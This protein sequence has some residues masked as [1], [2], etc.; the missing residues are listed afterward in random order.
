MSTDA[1]NPNDASDDL[2]TTIKESG[3]SMLLLILAAV[4]LL[5]YLP[6]MFEHCRVLW[7]LEQYQYFPFIIGAVAWLGWSRWQ[8][9][10]LVDSQRPMSWFQR[11]LHNVVPILLVPLVLVTLAIAVYCQWGWFA[12]VS[13]NL[14]L[15]AGLLV[16]TKYF[17]VRNAW[18]IWALMWL[19][20]PPPIEFGANV[21]QRL[22]L[23]SSLMGSKILDLLR[24]DHLMAGNVFTLPS[25]QLF[26][27]EAC[28]GIVSVMSVIAATGIYAVWKDR[29]L[30]HAGLLMLISVAWALVM[31]TVRIVLI[32]VA[33][34]WFSI[35]I[36]EGSAHE[37]LG[38]VLFSVTFMASMSTDQ[39][40]EF[41]L[42]PIKIP[43]GESGAQQ[44]SI[45]RCW[46]WA[47][48]S[49]APRWLK[50]TVQQTQL[51]RMLTGVMTPKLMMCGV[52]IAI[53]GV[54]ST[55]V[56]FGIV[57]GKPIARVEADKLSE[58]V[59]AEL[60]PEDLAGWTQTAYELS[61]RR[62]GEN[63]QGNYD[64]GQFSH[65]FTYQGSGELAQGTTQVSMDYPFTGGWHELSACYRASGWSILERDARS[66]GGREFVETTF[67]YPDQE[68][69]GYLLFNNFNEAG[70]VAP[71]P[72]GAVLVRSWLFIRRRFLRK[73]AGDLYQVQAF[74]T[75][76][77]PFTDEEKS[78]IKELFLDSE[79]RLT[80]H[81]AT[82]SSS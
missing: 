50:R 52:P 17:H 77:K 10:T 62:G 48:N 68:Q 46:N 37:V 27:D 47:A 39:F 45:I 26:V 66:E 71:P 70:E 81:I 8:D 12:A 20:V 75:S 2:K 29:S 24:I 21:V 14:L 58:S 43:P 4:V 74:A 65:S 42:S 41:V 82:L 73:V 16:L 36:A 69:Y 32:A 1:I 31:N 54:W 55:L 67:K 5:A 33:E 6:M 44:N 79:K 51:N 19:M 23:A 22:Q 56:F 61:D 7:E 30:I 76:D 25:K 53:L 80:T 72:S 9:A 63:M 35:D 64:F 60:L 3:N 78:K 28:S 15:G 11:T 34:S 57:G 49:F 59:T 38:L 40:L 18:G 13:L